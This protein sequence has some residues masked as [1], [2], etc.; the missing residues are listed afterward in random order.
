MG[1]KFVIVEDGDVRSYGFLLNTRRIE[2]TEATR[3][4]SKLGEMSS[5]LAGEGEKEAAGTFPGLWNHN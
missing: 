5:E 1:G 2:G 4:R 3:N